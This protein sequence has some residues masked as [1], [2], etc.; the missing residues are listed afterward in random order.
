[1]KNNKKL[2]PWE[3]QPS[4]PWKFKNITSFGWIMFFHFFISYPLLLFLLYKGI[5]KMY[6]FMF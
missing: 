1:M 5:I 2:E 4:R 6:N 3:M